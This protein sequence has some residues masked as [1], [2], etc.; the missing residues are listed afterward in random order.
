MTLSDVIIFLQIFFLLYF[1]SINIGYLGLILLSI[2]GVSQYM[3]RRSFDKLPLQYA[4]FEPPISL[5][6]PAY[7]EET[8]IATSVRSLLQLFYAEFEIIVINDGSKD[9]TIDVLRREFSL[10]PF[11]ES[12][13]QKL[14]TQTV[15]CVY[16]STI[17]P[18][19]R[20]IDKENGGKA[21]A[22]NAGINCCRYT[23]F[24]GMDADSILQVD[25]LHRVVQPIIEDPLAVAAGGTVRVANGCQVVGGFL[26]KADL[27][28]NLLALLQIVEY[29]RA[30]LFGR[31][32]WSRLNALL[33]I[34]GAFGLFNTEHVIAAGGY[35]T[36]TVGEDM[37]LVV[38]LHRHL[39]RAGKSSRITFIPDPICW[40][41]APEDLKTLKNQR[42]RWQCG[43]SESLTMNMGLLF[44]P[45]GGTVSWLAFPF[46]I[47]FE[48]LGPLIE[49]SGYVLITI[50]FFF[51]LVT[52]EAMAAFF[53]VAIGLGML[54]SAS[55][56]FLE[57]I[58]F[59]IYPKFKHIIILFLTIIVENFGYRQLTSVWR[60]IGLYHWAFGSKAHWG[61]M[62]RKATWQA[63]ITREA[64]KR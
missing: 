62:K 56:L 32:G 50:G 28:S 33:I 31:L 36:G 57:Q 26:V 47:V 20:V 15:R 45:R 29:L 3:Q 63:E 46:F 19:L 14:T 10:V 4:S 43:L 34:S 59:H 17:H 16:R 11:P 1:V 18:N 51:G 8:T 39:R 60:L 52:P 12:Y 23:M 41:E 48:W 5:L 9:K 13:P 55:A 35:R 22:L 64:D 21:D 37:E 38:R 40:S 61:E 2:F 24:C 6:V 53:L 7:N 58:S 25:S 54:L 42:I 49:V 27:P 44:N 30:F